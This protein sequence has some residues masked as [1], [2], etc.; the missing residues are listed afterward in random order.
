[1]EHENSLK[2][3]EE[4]TELIYWHISTVK[5]SAAVK[6]ERTTV[7]AMLDEKCKLQKNI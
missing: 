3:C 2:I 5:Y 1:M 7:K 4:C 6:N